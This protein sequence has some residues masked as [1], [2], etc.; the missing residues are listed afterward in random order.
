MKGEYLEMILRGVLGSPPPAY[1][2]GALLS[3]AVGFSWLGSMQE[4][5]VLIA[6]DKVLSQI[7]GGWPRP[8][9]RSGL[10][11]GNV[12]GQAPFLLTPSLQITLTL[13]LG[14]VKEA[15]K[16]ER[17]WRGVREHKGGGDVSQEPAGDG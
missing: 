14:L 2:D 12:A 1:R 4:R 3:W 11:A 10:R 13:A 5:G 9:P 15:G 17:I 7:F 16:G 8:S 6:G